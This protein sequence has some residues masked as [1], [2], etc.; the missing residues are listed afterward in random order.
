MTAQS[1]QFLVKAAT[2]SHMKTRQ[3]IAAARM[4]VVR[5]EG[6]PHDMSAVQDGK[7]QTT[8]RLP[9]SLKTNE[10]SPAEP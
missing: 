10:P 6:L 8:E 5:R 7:I 1:G 9:P 4:A 3:N 2:V